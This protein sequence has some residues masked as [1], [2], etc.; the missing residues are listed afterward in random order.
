M[1][2]NPIIEKPEAVSQTQRIAQGAVTVTC[3]FGFGFLLRP[4]FTLLGWIIGAVFF[5]REMVV[6]D[7]LRIWMRLLG[8]Y[9]LTVLAIGLTLKS[10]AWY[11]YRRFGTR[12]LRRT[13]PPSVT[14]QE[15]ADFNRVAPAELSLWRSSRRLVIRHDTQGR[16]L[17]VNN[18]GFRQCSESA[19]SRPPVKENWQSNVP[20]A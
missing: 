15:I 3:W 8:W 7:G 14:L 19:P 6:H 20:P 4:L 13:Y 5:S 16:I 2:R 1:T 12:N 17:Q 9:G 18:A 11:N 10:W